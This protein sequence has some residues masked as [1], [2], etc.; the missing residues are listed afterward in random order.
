M[1]ARSSFEV[2]TRT[3]SLRPTP[4]GSAARGHGG[5]EVDGGGGDHAHVHRVGAGAAHAL[6]LALLQRAQELD[7]H[8]G[9][10]RV[11]RL[12]PSARVWER[13]DH[14]LVRGRPLDVPVA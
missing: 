10:L 5:G 2:C 4:S 6:D 9:R 8:V 1:R 11:P 7:L 13:F 3:S 12:P 14:R